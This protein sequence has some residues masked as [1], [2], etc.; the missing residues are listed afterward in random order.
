MK[1][2]ISKI[3]KIGELLTTSVLSNNTV[4][5][6]KPMFDIDTGEETETVEDYVTLEEANERI[7]YIEKEISSLQ[8]SL[9]FFKSIVKQL[10]KPIAKTMA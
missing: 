10:E 3:D 8:K 4:K 1:I 6:S 7:A 2:D 5:L 9:S